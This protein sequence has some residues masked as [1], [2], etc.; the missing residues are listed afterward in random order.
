MVPHI[1]VVL[2]HF[3]KMKSTIS[4]QGTNERGVREFLAATVDAVSSAERV[5]VP[6]LLPLFARGMR[7][8]DSRAS[9]H[10]QPIAARL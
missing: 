1:E 2:I 5:A 4:M 9:G 7:L 3:G 6:V 8:Q 10:D